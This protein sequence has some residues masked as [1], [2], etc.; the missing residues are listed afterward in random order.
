MRAASIT[1]APEL[2]PLSANVTNLKMANQTVKVLY[3]TLGKLTGVNVLFDSDFVE[4]TKKF[5]IDLTNSTLEQA[6]D[7]V[8]ILSKTFWKPLSA[9]AIFVTKDDVTKRRDYEEHITRV[10]YLQNITSA[11][12]LQEAMTAMRT[13]T[14]VRKVFPFNSQS[15]LVVRGTAAQIALA[16]NVLMDIE[17]P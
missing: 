12:E 8:A 14:D 1:A 11:Q 6:L 5:S 2:R 9:N 16:E 17:K 15:A 7:Y 4:P 13:V 3:E 10:F